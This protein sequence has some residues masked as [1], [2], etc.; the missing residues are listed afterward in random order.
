[1]VMNKNDILKTED[2][3]SRTRTLEHLGRRA[4]CGHHAHFLLRG[5]MQVRNQARVKLLT[6]RI[7]QKKGSACFNVLNKIHVARPQQRDDV[8]RAAHIPGAP[9]NCEVRPQTPTADSYPIEIDNGGA[10]V[11]NVKDFMLEDDE[12]KHA[13]SVGRKERLRFLGRRH[14][15]Q[16]AGWRTRKSVWRPRVSNSTQF[17]DDED[18]EEIGEK[19][20]WM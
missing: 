3:A 11:F 20:E 16:V 10:G 18:A 12:W 5:V 7:E 15:R 6:A 1:M 8:V 19:A 13:R 9:S 2:L 17:V 14:C 4:W